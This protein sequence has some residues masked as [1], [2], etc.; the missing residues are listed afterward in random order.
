MRVPALPLLLLASACARPSSAS[1]QDA[2]PS[3]PT[4]SAVTA[5]PSAV[6]PNASAA[7][8]DASAVSTSFLP[9]TPPVDLP[10][11]LRDAVTAAASALHVKTVT[12]VDV[13]AFVL[14][15]A[16]HGA[17]FPA[18]VSLARKA[19]A[20]FFHGR[21]DRHPTRAVTVYVFSSPDAYQ[22]FCG[23]RAHG[24]CPTTFGEYDRLSREIVMHATRGAETLNHEMVHPIVEEDFPRAPAWL[25]E[26]IA[27]LYENPV[28]SCGEAFEPA[29]LPEPG[30]DNPLA[31]SRGMFITGVS[32]WRYP[33]VKRALDSPDDPGPTRLDALFA[34]DTFTFLTLDRA[35]PE[36]GP[37]DPA[38]ENRHYALARYFAQWLD[39]QGHLWPFYRA[40]RDGIAT[41]PTGVKAFAAVLGRS[42]GEA[43]ADWEAYVRRLAPPASENPCPR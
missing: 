6:T 37:T 16:D 10:T 23:A 38:K 43:D 41:D 25:D 30:S 2:A 1:P 31:R 18:A 13:D 7:T 4:A 32:N 36:T 12:H 9:P 26:G 5:D 3:T 35:H 24:P 34:M 11:S 14:V 39:R 28:F 8:A 22:C 33:D 27:S 29:S 40:W 19:V 17:N 20:A 21:F 42:P 15:D